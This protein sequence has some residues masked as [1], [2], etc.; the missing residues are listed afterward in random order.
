MLFNFSERIF[1]EIYE[2]RP[3]FRRNS[4]RLQHCVTLNP[5]VKKPKTFTVADN[6]IISRMIER[7]KKLVNS[8]SVQ[9]AFC[10]NFND[11]NEVMNLVELRVVREFNLPDT[12]ASVLQVIHVYNFSWLSLHQSVTKNQWQITVFV[13]F[14][15]LWI[16]KEQLSWIFL[17]N[18]VVTRESY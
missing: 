13:Y 8:H 18:S 15:T 3:K 1:L 14:F 12:Y 10:S 5:F 2:L 6:E 7:M 17:M 16:E 9:R 4:R 11:V